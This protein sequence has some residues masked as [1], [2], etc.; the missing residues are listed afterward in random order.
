MMAYDHTGS[1]IAF[2]ISHGLQSTSSVYIL[3]LQGQR[4]LVEISR[5]IAPKIIHD[6]AITPGGREIA[7]V[8]EKEIWLAVRAEYASTRRYTARKEQLPNELKFDRGPRQAA[9]AIY[10][11]DDGRG[12]TRTFARVV[13]RKWDF[14]EYSFYP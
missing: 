1:D 14:A 4:T 5:A 3:N 2:A 11:C 6:I 7:I 10:A 12:G 8:G 13:D 9:V